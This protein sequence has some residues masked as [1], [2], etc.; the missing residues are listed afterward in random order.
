MTNKNNVE[1]NMITDTNKAKLEAII[2]R[3]RELEEDYL[4]TVMKKSE[5]GTNE[6]EFALAAWD[7]IAS[8]VANKGQSINIEIF[9]AQL[10]LKHNGL[11]DGGLAALN[12]AYELVVETLRSVGV[13][14][15]RYRY[16][17][18]KA[19]ATNLERFYEYTE[20]NEI[21][22]VEKLYHQSVLAANQSNEDAVKNGALDKGLIEDPKQLVNCFP[23]RKVIV[24][25]AIFTSDLYD[26]L[27][28]KQKI[29]SERLIE[30]L[31]STEEG[32][33]AVS[34]AE[35]SLKNESLNKWL[36]SK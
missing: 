16:D 32:F 20:P 13:I 6:H 1:D 11:S 17:Y 33:L 14:K 23:A 19:G 29:S 5:M 12:R 4:K 34:V 31:K 24:F 10:Y 15:Y 18:H 3:T 35:A 21:E 26:P 25:D 30:Q 28:D 22:K 9:L 2:D 36:D 7:S 8:G 27:Y